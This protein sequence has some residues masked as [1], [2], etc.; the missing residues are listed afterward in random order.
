MADRLQMAL[1]S[2][3]GHALAVVKEND[4]YYLEDITA[5]PER[6][7]NSGVQGLIFNGI[8]DWLYEGQKYFK[9]MS[10]AVFS[11]RYTLIQ[12]SFQKFKNFIFEKYHKFLKF[13]LYLLD[14]AEFI[15]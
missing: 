11:D 10:N 13:K 7:T 6:L 9:F 12:I 2:P 3:V 14:I 4:L 15:S 5:Q 8:A 1:W